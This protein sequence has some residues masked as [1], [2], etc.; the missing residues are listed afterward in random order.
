[1]ALCMSQLMEAGERVWERN[2]TV[3]G[4]KWGQF[5]CVHSSPVVSFDSA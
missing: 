5:L 3:Y 2:V 4:C 1:M